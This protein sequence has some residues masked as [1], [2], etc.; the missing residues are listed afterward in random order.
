MA[1]SFATIFCFEFCFEAGSPVRRRECRLVADA[2]CEAN[3]SR[4][5]MFRQKRGRIRG[6]FAQFS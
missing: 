2:R 3:A 5:T 6:N 1:H 4:A